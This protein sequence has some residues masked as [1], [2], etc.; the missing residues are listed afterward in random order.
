MFISP[1]PHLSSLG[2]WRWDND[3]PRMGHTRDTPH[4]IGYHTQFSR[5][6]FYYGAF[7]NCVSCSNHDP[8]LHR[9]PKVSLVIYFIISEWI[10]SADTLCSPV[11]S[12]V[13]YPCPDQTQVTMDDQITSLWVWGWDGSRRNAIRCDPGLETAEILWDWWRC[14]NE[15]LGYFPHWHNYWVWPTLTMLAG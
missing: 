11:L 1:A 10:L 3:G 12:P 13:E 15:I 6:S 2:H 4:G 5:C 9:L 8:Y 14:F 7:R